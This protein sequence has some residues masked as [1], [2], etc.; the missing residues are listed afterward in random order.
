MTEICKA[1]A[2]LSRLSFLTVTENLMRH[3]LTFNKMF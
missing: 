3:T 2:E 1:A